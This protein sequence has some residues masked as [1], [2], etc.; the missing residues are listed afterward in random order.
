MQNLRFVGVPRDGSAAGRGAALVDPDDGLALVGVAEAGPRVLQRREFRVGVVAPAVAHEP[1]DLVEGRLLRELEELRVRMG[2]SDVRQLHPRHVDAEEL[3]LRRRLDGLDVVAPQQR[4]D[5]RGRRDLPAARHEHGVRL[6]AEARPRRERAEGEQVQE[7]DP[8]PDVRAEPQRGRL[9]LPRDAADDPH[10]DHGEEA[11]RE[12]EPEP[13]E[14]RAR[15]EPERRHE[16][17]RDRVDDGAHA[18]ALERVRRADP[19]RRLVDAIA[20]AALARRVVPG[21]ARR[22]VGAE[23]HQEQDEARRVVDRAAI[24]GEHREHEAERA[25]RPAADAD[26]LRVRRHREEDDG[27]D[28]I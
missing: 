20:A 22:R 9:R 25:R 23:G 8:A 24:R 1:V 5:A 7:V 13:V 10:A 16:A 2:R 12:D 19:A 14:R 28:E 21:E 11:P 18:P 17:A 27:R 26:P 4:R 3:L 6:L 15:V